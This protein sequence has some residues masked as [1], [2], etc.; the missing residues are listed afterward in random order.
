MNIN[1]K[2]KKI[3]IYS[4]CRNLTLEVWCQLCMRAPNKRVLLLFIMP[5]YQRWLF[6]TLRWKQWSWEMFGTRGHLN[7]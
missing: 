2:K 3:Y 6:L 7:V 4:R 1:H 5:S